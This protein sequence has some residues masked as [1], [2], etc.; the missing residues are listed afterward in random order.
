MRNI[1]NSWKWRIA[2]AVVLLAVI[3]VVFVSCSGPS[4][5]Q[6]R[7]EMQEVTGK[8]TKNIAVL[9]NLTLEW[10]NIWQNIALGGMTFEEGVAK[11]NAIS[12][13]AKEVS[14]LVA[15]SPTPKWLKEKPLEDFDNMKKDIS[16][17]ANA[18]AV[19]SKA[20]AQMLQAGKLTAGDISTMA[21]YSKEANNY[22]GK[23]ISMLNKFRD[24]YGVDK[25]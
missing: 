7:A 22:L 13:A 1:K 12:V 18:L 15:Q 3:S 4:P 10:K 6:K 24:G 8:I 20:G 5:E 14:E 17:S 23:T 21:T 11:L 2:I 19:A 25:K 9:E 16:L